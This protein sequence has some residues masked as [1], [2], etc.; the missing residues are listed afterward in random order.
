MQGTEAVADPDRTTVAFTKQSP[1][2]VS[3]DA[4]EVTAFVG[5]VTVTGDTGT[6][7]AVDAGSSSS[8]APP[9]PVREIITAM[10]ITKLAMLQ[11]F[12]RDS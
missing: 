4:F 3:D 7:A 10:V 12:N 1:L 9:Q 2:I 6:G 5:F 11:K 8:A